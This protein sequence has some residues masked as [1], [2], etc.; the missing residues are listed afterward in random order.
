MDYIG[1]DVGKHELHVALL[2]DDKKLA[3]KTVGN[4]PK[5]FDQLVAWLSNRKAKAPHICMEA[6]GSYGIGIAEFL[7]EHG[8]L[9]SVVNPS[10]I[11]AF[12]QS[13]L[14]RTKT[15]RVDA[16]LIAEFCKER[17][18]NA[19]E[20]PPLEI[21]ALRAMVRRRETLTDMIVAESNRLE[22]AESERVE[23]SINEHVS[24]LKVALAKLESEMD[25]HLDSHPK[26]RDLVDRLDEIPG[27]GALTAMK[28]VAETSGFRV[29]QTASEL[30]AY[31]GLNPRQYQSGGISR[32][33]SISKIGN[34]SLRKSLYCAALSAKRTSLYFRSFVER[35]KAAGKPPKLIVTAIMRKLLVLAHTLAT[36]NTRF[37]AARA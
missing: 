28:V 1:V 30:V 14:I 35:L 12:G 32:R 26:L 9:V 25:D 27:F 10:Q 31:A 13:A 11:K 5:G 8:Y 33:G 19:W 21:R 20:P 22:G 18:P 4:N 15:D 6:T 3:R 16:A 29:C 23:R 2:Q 37:E 24:F 36:K 17:R 34:A 7:H